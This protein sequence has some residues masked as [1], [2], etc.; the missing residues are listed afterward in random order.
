MCWRGKDVENNTKNLGHQNTPASLEM[1]TQKS[2]SLESKGMTE[3]E[4]S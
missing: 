1:L 4:N 2:L 3:Q